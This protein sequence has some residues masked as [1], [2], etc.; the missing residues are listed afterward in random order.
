MRKRQY[1][2][3]VPIFYCW[4]W[5]VSH[6]VHSVRRPT[7][8]TGRP[9]AVRHPRDRNKSLSCNPARMSRTSGS[10]HD[11][12]PQ[13]TV[14]S[15]SHRKQAMKSTAICVFLLPLSRARQRAFTLIEVMIVVAIIAILAA[16]A[17][18]SYNDYIT[19]GRL[20]EGTNALAALRA[21]M[22]R[23]FQDN[24]TYLTVTVGGTTFTSPCGALPTVPNFTLSCP[25]ATL[26]A[27]TYGL[28]ATGTGPL[29]GIA[30]TLDQV[31]AATTTVSGSFASWSP[32][33]PAACWVTRRGQTC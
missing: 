3:C 24:R 4:L 27:V 17:L 6:L 10:S 19:R 15:P 16:I 23:H 5:P 33:S 11:P 13:P 21:N 9:I 31:N 32:T 30:F 8:A 29:S 1:A 7:A 25:P 26:T 18:P 20:V 2:R 14:P 28:T 22:E 12:A